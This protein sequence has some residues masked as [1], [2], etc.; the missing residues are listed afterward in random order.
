MRIRPLLT[1]LSVICL[2][3]TG[4][5]V[6]ESGQMAMKDTF[7]SFRPRPHDEPEM[8]ESPED[9]WGFV[10][11]EGRADQAIERDP[12]W[13]VSDKAMMIKRNLGVDQ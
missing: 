11:R 9:E 13:L 1:I 7:R 8:I 5:S 4:C 2:S 3:S 12:D 10:F 6:F